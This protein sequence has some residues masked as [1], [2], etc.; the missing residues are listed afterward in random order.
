MQCVFSKQLGET[1][2]H[3]ARRVQIKFMRKLLSTPGLTVDVNWKNEDG[4]TTIMVVGNHFFTCDD[5]KCAEV[6]DFLAKNG[7]DLK[8]TDKYGESARY[9]F[10]NTVG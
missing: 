1:F 3:A 9:V 10:Y 4:K 7:A 5:A 8:A 6:Y 2:H